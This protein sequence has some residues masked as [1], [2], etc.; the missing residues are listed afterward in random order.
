MNY[1]NVAVPVKYP[2][3]DKNYTY[4]VPD[5][6]N[7]VPGMRVTV[8]FGKKEVMGIITEVF[9]EEP[10][11]DFRLRKI[12]DLPDE[13]VFLSK[14]ALETAKFMEDRY[15]TGPYQSLYPFLFPGDLRDL[16]TVTR[17]EKNQVYYID[18]RQQKRYY[19]RDGDR[20]DTEAQ[21]K[22]IETLKTY[23]PLTASEI[24]EKGGVSRSPIDTLKKRKI[25]FP[26]YGGIE[27]RAEGEEALK[28][29][30]EQ[31]KALRGI[32]TS[33]HSVNLLHGLTGSGKTEIYLQLTEKVLEQKG[34][35]IFLVP[36]IS[37]TP[38][39]IGRLE[40]RFPGN[41][42]VLHSK[43]SAMERRREWLKIYNGDV[44]VAVGVRS[45]VFAPFKNTDLII[46]DEEQEN[47]YGY[48]NA[49]RYDAVEVAEKRGELTGAK[50]LFGSATP[51]IKTFQRA[52]KGEIG[53][54]TLTRRPFSGRLP[55]TV[56]VDM[57]EELNKGNVSIFSER[58]YDEIGF[59][60]ER[61]EQVI[62]F[63]NRRGYSNFISCRNCGH[64]IQCDYC[65]IS[66][67]YHKTI[68]RLRCHYCGAT[69][70]YPSRCPKCGSKFIK[71]FGIGTQQVEEEVRRLFPQARVHRMDRDTTYL[72]GSYD[73]VYRKM[74]GGET[75]IL[76]GTQMLAKGMDFPNVTL[77][78]IIA[79]DLSLYISDFR[80][81]E[82]TFQLISQ[83]SGRAGRGNRPGHVILQTYN[84]DNYSLQLACGEQYRAFYEKETELREQFF[85]PP[86]STMAE[87]S[88]TREDRE[89][90]SRDCHSFYQQLVEMYPKDNLLGTKVI[91]TPKIKNKY[92]FRFQCKTERSDEKLLRSTLHRVLDKYNDLNRRN[93]FVDIYFY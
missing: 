89:E 88:V 91:E 1:C 50:V 69:K 25:L 24:T 18:K 9:K 90:A 72:K 59:A 74:T 33:G 3:M 15:F 14:E 10:E 75:D 93:M 19:F 39:M 52:E 66:M 64:V 37:L 43:L 53:L 20:V 80:A 6:M 86:F 30:E 2:G 79:A 32:E 85:Y 40:S 46:V 92:T 81:Q 29:T 28:L 68:H 31:E 65:D 49:L 60:L 11:T 78:G 71:S 83:V 70:P 36:E 63:L 13:G 12:I 67:N 54:F 38:Q 44:S 76:I 17:K 62:L 21:K 77:V 82:N 87:I 34:N 48:H 22:V 8:P 4:L 5:D 27:K 47:S 35:V 57:R 45:A 58:L 84:P 56:L 26:Y 16:K 55:E 23:G 61:K 73:E 7:A 42:S 51:S 41:I